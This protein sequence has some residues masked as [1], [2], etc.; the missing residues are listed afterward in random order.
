MH[1]RGAVLLHLVAEADPSIPVIFVDTQ[2]MFPETLAYRETLT[3]LLGLANS[4]VIRPDAAD[5]RKRAVK[6]V[7]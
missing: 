4:S 6:N 7:I 3:R 1:A 5:R 2:K